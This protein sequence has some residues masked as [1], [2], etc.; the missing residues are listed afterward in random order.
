VE[1][2]EP[3]EVLLDDDADDGMKTGSKPVRIHRMALVT[4]AITIRHNQTTEVP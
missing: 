1:A 2:P 4:E 3:S